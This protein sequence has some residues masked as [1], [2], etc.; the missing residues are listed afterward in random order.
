MV[1]RAAHRRRA[2]RLQSQ[3]AR[4]GVDSCEILTVY[5]QYQAPGQDDATWGGEHA[6]AWGAV[7]ISRRGHMDAGRSRDVGTAAGALARAGRIACFLAVV[8]TGFVLF[9]TGACHS[10]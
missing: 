6:M 10:S 5:C 7:T 8:A 1:N 2:S 4:N 3:R 9:L